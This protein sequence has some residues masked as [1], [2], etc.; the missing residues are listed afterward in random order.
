MADVLADR[1][2]TREEADV[3]PG[4]YLLDPRKGAGKGVQPARP[5]EVAEART[6]EKVW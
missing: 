4:Q 5:L 1:L 2:T 6:A 3:H